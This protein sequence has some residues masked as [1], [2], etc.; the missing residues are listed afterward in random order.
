MEDAVGVDGDDE[1]GGGVVERIAHRAR[2]AAVDVVATA[3]DADVGEV[4]LRFE[5]PLEAVI[6]RTIVLRN[7]FK[8]FVRIVAPADALNGPIDSFAFVVA[9]KQ[10]ADGGLPSVILPDSRGRKGQPQD[11]SHEVFDY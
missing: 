6:A 5:H 4:P 10:H 11:Q 9:G 8:E 3:T 7:H 1:F 2:L